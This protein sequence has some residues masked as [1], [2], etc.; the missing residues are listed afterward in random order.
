[1][2]MRRIYLLGNTVVS[3][4]II[5]EDHHVYIKSVYIKSRYELFMNDVP[6]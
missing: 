5:G 6:V 2:K 1:M 4:H 3:S